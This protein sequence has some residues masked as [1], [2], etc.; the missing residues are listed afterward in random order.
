MCRRAESNPRRPRRL[1]L[2][3]D[4]KPTELRRPS[5]VVALIFLYKPNVILLFKL[6]VEL[7]FYT[8]VDRL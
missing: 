1:D 5:N 3:A 8:N 6:L 2:K 7:T 4:A